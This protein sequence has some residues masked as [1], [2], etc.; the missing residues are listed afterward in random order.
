MLFKVPGA[1]SSSIIIFCISHLQVFDFWTIIF[2][3]L[4]W[5][6]RRQLRCVKIGAY[7][8]LMIAAA[9]RPSPD[10]GRAAP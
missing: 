8:G 10:L 3:R 5:H 6:M 1:G 2:S 9:G 4:F 7:T